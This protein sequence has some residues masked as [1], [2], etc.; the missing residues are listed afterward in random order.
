MSRQCNNFN[1]DYP[2][3]RLILSM[4]P[5]TNNNMSAKLTN[6]NECLEVELEGQLDMIDNYRS[7][8]GREGA[9]QMKE[10]DCWLPTLRRNV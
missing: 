10:L 2:E 7:F 3:K 9:S 5:P 4:P 8:S 1:K 6:I